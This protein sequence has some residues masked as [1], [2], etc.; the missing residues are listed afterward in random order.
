MARGRRKEFDEDY[1]L[2]R[3]MQLFWLKGYGASGLTE[4]VEHMGISRQSLYDTFGSKR[5][6]FLRCL[7]LYKRTQL[8]DAL[9]LLER[10]GSS[11]E[12]VKALVRF[13]RDLALD[14][15]CRGCSV[16]NSLVEFGP[17][18]EGIAAVL[19]ETLGILQHAIEAALERAR[20][21]GELPA[22]KSPEA[23]SRALINAVIGLAV[24]GRL[25]M[26]PASVHVAYEGTL[27][28]LD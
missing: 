10:E 11:V 1:A 13:F 23:L 21:N 3:A 6:L 4:L 12:N 18:D 14:G 5:D 2:D 7:E 24:T 17:R 15:R 8:T 16:A 9:R 26:E 20:S 22:R 19:H 27:S 25:Q 28:M